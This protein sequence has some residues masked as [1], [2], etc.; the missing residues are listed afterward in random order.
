MNS[1][2]VLILGLM[3]ISFSFGVMSKDWL[4]EKAHQFADWLTKDLDEDE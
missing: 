3:F 2:V 1:L 4:D